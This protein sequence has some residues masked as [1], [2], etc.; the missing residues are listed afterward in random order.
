MKDL[1]KVLFC[2]IIII[3]GELKEFVGFLMCRFGKFRRDFPFYS[4]NRSRNRKNF[5]SR[6]RSFKSRDKC[7]TRNERI[8]P[9]LGDSQNCEAGRGVEVGDTERAV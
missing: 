6:S 3:V 7:E 1:L 5:A 4:P 9:G 8:E 2:L